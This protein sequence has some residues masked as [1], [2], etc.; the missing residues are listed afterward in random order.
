MNSR[1]KGM[2][3]KI[4]IGKAQLGLDDD[5][6]R[7][8]LVANTGKN[9]CS[10]M[11]LNELESVLNAM[12]KQGFKAVAKY[13]KK[14]S[15]R[16]SIRPMIGKV[17]AILAEQGLHWNYAHGMAKSMFSVDQVHWLND[18]QLY[19]LVGALQIYANRHKKAN[20]P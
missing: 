2:V 15:A 11:N 16:K 7:S 4:H 8:L 1:Y 18:E 19:R 5:T 10:K 3:A 6:Y 17:S 13:G 14:P 20:Q 9:S 12:Q